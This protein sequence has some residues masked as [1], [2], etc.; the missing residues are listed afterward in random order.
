[1]CFIWTYIYIL[2]QLVTA[3]TKRSQL[4]AHNYRW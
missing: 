2:V 4:L 1:V 3:V